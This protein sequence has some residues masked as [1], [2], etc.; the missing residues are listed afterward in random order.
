MPGEPPG[1]GRR[2]PCSPKLS[3]LLC[4]AAAAATV[5][6][7]LPGE[8]LR[9]TFPDGYVLLAAAVGPYL[10]LGGLAWLRRDEPRTARGLFVLIALLAVVGLALIGSDAAGYRSALARQSARAG[11][12]ERT[13]PA[14]GDFPGAGGAMA[15]GI[16][17]R[18]GHAPGRV[19]GQGEKCQ[20]MTFGGDRL[21]RPK[22][23]RRWQATPS[24][25]P[26]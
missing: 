5:A 24:G 3:V 25:K 21:I 12:P 14:Y 26:P 11:L 22:A 16:A 7:V 1:T 23:H 2:I 4:L 8:Y 20:W 17:G 9:L 6:L 13:L 18:R 19:S 15:S 10:L